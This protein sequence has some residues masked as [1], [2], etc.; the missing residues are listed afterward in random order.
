MSLI[1]PGLAISLSAHSEPKNVKRGFQVKWFDQ[2]KWIHYDEAADSVFCHVCAKVEEEG[3]LK[4]T[5][6]DLAFI[7]K[8]YTNWKDATE[9]FRRNEKSNCHQEAIQAVLIPSNVPDIGEMVSNLYA[10]NKVQNR[11]LFLKI[12]QNIKFL[13][14]QGLYSLSWPR[15]TQK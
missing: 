4:S 12:L 7:K 8:G 14:R 9:S 11:K 3:I 10:Q 2:W 6:K 15:W 5:S 13:A 1:N